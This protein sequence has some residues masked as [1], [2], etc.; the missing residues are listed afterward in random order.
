LGFSY[1]RLAQRAARDG[2]EVETIQPSKWQLIIVAVLGLIVTTSV[3]STI[4][5]IESFLTI[6]PANSKSQLPSKTT[7]VRWSEPINIA[8]STDPISGQPLVV[9]D[10][11]GVHYKVWCGADGYVQYQKGTG[12]VEQIPF[13]GCTNE[14]TIAI[15]SDGLPHVVWYAEEITDNFGNIR[16]TSALVES[17]RPGN[18]CFNR[19]RC[20]A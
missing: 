6:Q 10:I 9:Q 2:V 18:R 12:P 8:N 16:S 20:P 1:G 19:N 17:K 3:L 4:G 15:D 5:Q 14:P 7:S 13:P 11:Q